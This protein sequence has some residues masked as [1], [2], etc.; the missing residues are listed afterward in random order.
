MWN[1]LPPSVRVASSISGFKKGV[2]DY[3]MSRNIGD[4]FISSGGLPCMGIKISSAGH[5][6]GIYFNCI[7]FYL[8]FALLLAIKLK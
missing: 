1:V 5:P 3:L 6:Y 8:A 4:A 7:V 2:R